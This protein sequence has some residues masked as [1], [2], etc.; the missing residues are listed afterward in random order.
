MGVCRAAASA[1]TPWAQAHVATAHDTR[2][3]SVVNDDEMLRAVEESFLH[4]V[5]D[6][7]IDLANERG[8]PDN[9]TVI[10]AHAV[11][12]ALLSEAEMDVVSL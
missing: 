12:E 11:D 1:A 2:S 3:R 10:V 8:G 5:P 9:I 6:V 7:L 4:R